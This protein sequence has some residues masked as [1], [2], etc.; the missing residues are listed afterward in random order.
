MKTYLDNLNLEHILKLM[1]IT[2]AT[3]YIIFIFWNRLFRLRLPR[4]LDGN[5]T[6]IQ[7]I[8]FTLI[9][10]SCLFI[11]IHSL[12]KLFSKKQTSIFKYYINYILE[13]R[14]S[15][16]IIKYIINAP[17]HLYDLLYEYI[18]IRPFIEK[19]GVKVW[20]MDPY[21]YCKPILF[22]IYSIR[23]FVCIIFIID[24]IYF[25]KFNYFYKSLILLL[26]P[27]IFKTSIY[28][29]QDMS[30]KNKAYIEKEFLIIEVNETRDGFYADP[31]EKHKDNMSDNQ[32]NILSISW[33]AYLA[34]CMFTDKI[35]ELDNIYKKYV[36]I[37]CYGIYT[38]GW[39]YILYTWLFAVNIP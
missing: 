2:L 28:I 7:L 18:T 35:D 16:F 37:I 20:N 36:D 38:I 1:S 39:G 4:I 32:L 25:Q 9:F 11:L 34:N 17:K 31:H 15:K 22:T 30:K 8:A 26:I 33:V 27:I 6:D 12:H 5:Y 13:T 10:F 29:I 24:I 23:I 3:I 14:I 19:I 21:D